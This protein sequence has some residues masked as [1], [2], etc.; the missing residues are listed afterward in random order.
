[1]AS[2]PTCRWL[3]SGLLGFVL[4]MIWRLQSV[5]EDDWK[6]N[7]AIRDLD[8]DVS[9][10]G[11]S[12]SGHS[13]SDSKDDVSFAEGINSDYSAKDSVDGLLTEETTQHL[14]VDSQPTSSVERDPLGVGGYSDYNLQLCEHPPSVFSLS[15]NGSSDAVCAGDKLPT[16]K[17]NSTFSLCNNLSSITFGHDNVHK[18]IL[19]TREKN[20]QFVIL[21]DDDY[22]NLCLPLFLRFNVCF[23]QTFFTMCYEVS[24]QESERVTAYVFFHSKQCPLSASMHYDHWLIIMHRHVKGDVEC[25]RKI[26]HGE[27]RFE[28]NE[29]AGIRFRITNFDKDVNGSSCFTYNDTLF[30]RVGNET[31]FIYFNLYWPC[32]YPGYTVA[33]NG[34]P[35]EHGLNGEWS[36][37][38]LSCQ[39]GEVVLMVVVACVGVSGVVGNLVVVVVMVNGPHRGQESSMLRTSLAFADLFLA[40][41]VVVPSLYHHLKPFLTHPGIFVDLDSNSSDSGQVVELYSLRDINK[42]TPLFQ[43]FLFCQC[44]IV[45][46]L[47]VFLLSIERL[48]L[49]NRALRYHHYFTVTRVKAAICLTWIIGLL[50]SLIFMYHEDGH[51]AAYWSTFNKLPLPWAFAYPDNILYKTVYYSQLLLLGAVGICTFLFSSLAIWN[52]LKEQ[53]RTASEWKGMNMFIYGPMAEENRRSLIT[54]VLIT[55]CHLISNIPLLVDV[56]IIYLSI[57]FSFKPVLRSYICWWL[58]LSGIAWNPWIYNSRGQQFKKDA[59]LVFNK[60]LPD[61]L[62]RRLRPREVPSQDAGGTGDARTRVRRRKMLLTLGLETRD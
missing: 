25:I 31:K 37:L 34:N 45:S 55:V 3:R 54:Q 40:A 29:V 62:R 59:T 16:F 60:L 58:F 1:M 11:I 39:A 43:A 24:G 57:E 10:G 21:Y 53:A 26:C 48:V 49:T 8:D 30:F 27:H 18:V 19:N 5:G 12:T 46:L 51:F 14:S 28:D 20:E 4:F 17:F 38:P 13:T 36:Y 23:N 50:D 2:R 47:T 33:W 52:F 32:C 9:W 6:P 7:T 42:S 61:A 41:F 56:F 15:Y 22:I 35:E 44:S